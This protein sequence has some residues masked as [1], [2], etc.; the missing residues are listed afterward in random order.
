[1]L[2]QCTIPICDKP[3]KTRGFCKAHYMRWW[4]HGDPLAGGKPSLVGHP[5]EARF[6]QKVEKSADC[7]NWIGVKNSGGYGQLQ[8]KGRMVYA[9]RYAYE[10]LTGPIPSGLTIDHLC[11]NRACVYPAHMEPVSRGGNVLRGEAPT[12]YNARKTHCKH[13][14]PF[15]AANTYFRLDRKGRMCR[16]CK[17]MRERVKCGAELAGG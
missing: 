7:W 16:E 17:R 2:P 4:R 3:I 14:H 6:W 1:M 8:V 15:N 9:H 13:G 11:R 5:A 12:A 10:L